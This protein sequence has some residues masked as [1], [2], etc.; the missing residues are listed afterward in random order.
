MTGA[1]PFDAFALP[2]DRLTV[3]EAS[4]GTGKTHTITQ[5]YVRLLLE[6]ELTVDRL[7]VVT[8]TKAATQELRA[9]LRKLLGDV[10][11]VLAGQVV[12]DA[13]ANDLA[14]RV[15][16]RE[17]AALL[18]EQ[19]VAS[20]DDAAIFTIHAF[21]QRVLADSA[22]ES[23]APF[24]VELVADQSELLQEVVDD[25]WRAHV[26]TASPAFVEYLLLDK[27]KFTPDALCDLLRAHVGRPDLLVRPDDSPVAVVEAE[28]AFRDAC[29]VARPLWIADRP[30]IAAAFASPALN[31]SRYPAAKVEPR[32]VRMDEWLSA[33]DPPMSRFKDFEL[34]AATSLE[35]A[36]KV[37]QPVPRHAFF[38]ACDTIQQTAEALTV[39]YA[40]RKASLK[41]RLLRDGATQL[42]ARKRDRRLQSY[43]DLLQ[44]L[45][46]ALDDDRRG[47]RLALAVRE[48]WEAALIDEFQDT[49]PTQ[50]HI[51]RRI[52]GGTDTP[53]VLV[54][55]PKQAIYS[56]RG[57][58]VFTYLVA[59]REAAEPRTLAVNWRTD[60]ALLEGV[61]ALF[62]RGPRPFL[63]PDIEFQPVSAAPRVRDQ[64][65]VDGDDG[66]PLRLWWMADPD[67]DRLT[68]GEARHRAAR[69][70]AAEIARLLRGASAGTARLGTRPLAGADIAVLVRTHREGR[71][72]RSALSDRGIASVQHA[73]DS[74]F[75]TDEA[76]ELERI[77][78][79]AATPGDA[80]RVRAALATDILGV[81]ADRLLALADDEPAW[82]REVEDF[83][84]WHD[85]WTTRGFARMFRA[86]LFGREV[87][88][89]LLA[90]PDGERRL[91][92]LLH[93]G[94]LL[95]A[96]SARR[97]GGMD[98]L[99]E[100]LQTRRRETQFD[101]DEQQLRLES[102]DQL[103]KI[104][105]IHKS[106][107][108]EY[109]IVFC[110]FLWDG[111]L[112][113][114]KAT[115]LTFH[116]AAG[117][118]RATLDLG[119]PSFA[120]DR[121]QAEREELAERL[122]LAY[123]ALTR[124]Q[125][126]CVVVAG[127]VNELGTS[128]LGWLLHAPEDAALEGPPKAV[129]KAIEKRDGAVLYGEAAA[130]AAR[131]PAAIALGGLPADDVT[132]RV[133]E[134]P[135]T[136]V[137]TP[138]RLERPV[139]PA[140]RVTSFSALV[141]AREAERP[142]YDALPAA[143]V[144]VPAAPGDD[145][146]GFPRG[147]RAGRCLHAIFERVD[148]T[149]ADPA[150]LP[151]VTAAALVEHGFGLEWSGTVQSMV[152]RV[153]ATGLDVDGSVRLAAVPR[154][155]RFDELEFTHTLAPLDV[156]GLRGILAAHGYGSEPFAAAVAALDFPLV[157]GFMKGFI[158]CVFQ[159]GG[160]W[161]VIDYKSNWLGATADDY[162]AARLPAA[163]ARD[164]Y[165]LQYLI[166]TVVVHRYLRV[167]LADYD[168]DRDFGGV[169]YLF[170]RGIGPSRG[171]ANGVFADRPSR[172]LVEA[173]DTFMARGR[174]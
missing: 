93:Q 5:L 163:I 69:A 31:G 56:F 105:T 80:A 36:T 150:E 164:S 52:W 76:A 46:A 120:A 135:S 126:R 161:Y 157:H 21:C 146:A 101:A 84:R 55:D 38:T 20:F 128:P 71:L 87:P 81:P 72:V 130:L 102:D 152:E 54:G 39:A 17:R 116:D 65:V 89:R 82:E 153:L 61:E 47:A 70:T 138:R 124:A 156:V 33:D 141:A 43:D 111:H 11:A 107:G 127:P 160:R 16:D 143:D 95:Q 167:R 18:L 118:G 63:I 66:P 123:V 158:D 92:N 85:E 133:G 151:R 29:A 23:G 10:R 19:A 73:L 104:V 28:A 37:R 9:R 109:P 77:L 50:Y 15:P 169:F 103:V 62:R 51:V 121:A 75:H 110:P 132:L 100:W 148:F 108:L 4:A 67:G 86:L 22:F 122:R 57:A 145:I 147:A 112:Q 125:H 155:R 78:L 74:V 154:D 12:D 140:W 6:R 34:F 26:A 113:A 88:A 171:A 173:L 83:H 137:L 162:A 144:V 168:Y 115:E 117:A 79:A 94:E 119:S 14:A 32:L 13:L 98:G 165:F 136:T 142:D 134:A 53:V 49:D 8:Y 172:A 68:K 149:R 60:A 131:A 45:R 159:A 2:L 97:G 64:L 25:F 44:H 40:A 91:T 174:V 99:L 48:R 41:A 59:R 35:K 1:A 30:A 96:E 139:P 27:R 90:H 106:K 3:I 114:S 42:A 24:E 129:G 7:L 58:D 166:Y 170:L